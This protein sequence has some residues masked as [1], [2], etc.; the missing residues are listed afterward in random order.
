MAVSSTKEA[1][2]GVRDTLTT[3]Q[4]GFND[5][6]HGKSQAQKMAGLRNAIVWGRTVTQSL[7]HIKTFE[8]EKYEK[9]YQPWKFKL[10]NN[11]T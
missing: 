3:A 6:L 11:L 10:E 4:L 1:L 2:N 7:H 8:R 5:F 9:W